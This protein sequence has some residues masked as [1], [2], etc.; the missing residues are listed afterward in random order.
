MFSQRHG[1][2]PVRPYTGN[3]AAALNLLSGE[4]RI[5]SY[6]LRA[7]TLTNGQYNRHEYT[8]TDKR[9]NNNNTAGARCVIVRVECGKSKL[10]RR[11][12]QRNCF[13]GRGRES[14]H[15]PARLL[16]KA[17]VAAAA[18]SQSDRQRDTRKIGDSRLKYPDTCSHQLQLEPRG[19]GVHVSAY[20]SRPRR[21]ERPGPRNSNQLGGRSRSTSFYVARREKRRGRFPLRG[22]A[23]PLH[24]RRPS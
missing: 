18:L 6:K 8:A 4:I 3:F 21:G 23:S 9:Y 17:A 13:R 19:Y 16:S 11:E 20:V 14:F 24:R 12:W 2:P 1:D 7:T 5:T 15:L 22:R 10:P